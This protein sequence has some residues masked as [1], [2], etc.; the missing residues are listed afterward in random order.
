[1]TEKLAQAGRGGGC[2]IA[3]I[4]YK[5]VVYAPAVRADAFPLFLHYPTPIFLYSE[6]IRQPEVEENYNWGVI[7]TNKQKF[8]FEP[9][10]T[11]T[12]SVSV[13]FRFVSWNQKLK[14]QFVVC[15]E[16]LSKQPKQTE[17]FWNKKKQP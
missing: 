1:M 8:R 4:S 17:L 9:K 5:V 14:F 10:Q 7:E 11:K 15:F 12:R 6:G 3:T 16:P 2:T 13:V